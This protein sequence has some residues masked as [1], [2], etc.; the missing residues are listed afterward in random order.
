MTKKFDVYTLTCLTLIAKQQEE[1][2][3]QLEQ[4]QRQID[5][6]REFLAVLI[7]KVEA[8]NR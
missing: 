7:E 1:I 5:N 6:D 4:K 2:I 8:A 3:R